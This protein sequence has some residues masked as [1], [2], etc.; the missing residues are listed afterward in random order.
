MDDW[1]TLDQELG[2]E[3]EGVQ[4]DAMKGVCWA[5]DYRVAW[6]GGI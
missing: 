3:V 6:V 2:A 5:E 4:R 1:V